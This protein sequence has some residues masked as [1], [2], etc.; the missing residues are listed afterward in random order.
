MADLMT[1][2]APAVYNDLS[3]LQN[4]RL[5][6]RENPEGALGEVA[7]QFESVFVTMM[8]KAMRDTLPQDGMFASSQ[9]GTYQEMFDQQLALDLSRHS[10]LGLA[11]LIEKQLAA[12]QRYI[13]GAGSGEPGS[14]TGVS[15]AGNGQ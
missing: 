13:T 7:K 4:L 11:S 5:Q 8:L 2:T 1:G 15:D 10:G 3:G 14:N 9:M 12:S 6:S